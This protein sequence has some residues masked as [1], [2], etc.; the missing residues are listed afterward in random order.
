M[1]NEDKNNQDNEKRNRQEIRNQKNIANNQ[2][3][4]QNGLKGVTTAA[5]GF[6]GGKAGA[7]IGSKVG[8][9][10]NNSKVGQAA[11]N[12][13]GRAMNT[14]NNIL[15]GGR[16][17]QDTLNNTI[18]NDTSNKVDNGIDKSTSTDTPATS[19]SNKKQ[20]TKQDNETFISSSN[21][22]NKQNPL[23]NRRQSKNNKGVINK[24]PTKK[25]NIGDKHFEHVRNEKPSN[26]D[27]KFSNNQEG[28]KASNAKNTQEKQKNSVDNKKQDGKTQEK[29]GGKKPSFG[30][31]FGKRALAGAGL[32][33]GRSLFNRKSKTETEEE[34][35]TTEETTH[36]AVRTVKSIIAAIHA[37]IALLPVLGITLIIILI[38]IGIVVFLSII[39]GLIPYGQD[40]DGTVCFVAST[41][42]KVIIDDKEYDMD[43][44][45]AGA[46]VNYYKEDDLK[47]ATMTTVSD[48]ILQA[49]AVVIHSDIST[50]S[51]YDSVNE[52][53]TVNDSTRFTD[54]YDYDSSNDTS[55]TE[56]TDGGGNTEDTTNT[57]EQTNTS[58]EE[59]SSANND[60]YY[61]RAKNAAD[62]VIDKVID[63]YSQNIE[64]DYDGYQDKLTEYANVD[65][66]TI[67]RIYI[68]NSPTYEKTNKNGTD[69]E[70]TEDDIKEDSD[71]NPIGIYPICYH[72]KPTASATTSTVYGEEVCTTVHINNGEYA[73]DYTIDEYIAGVVYHEARA[74]YKTLDMMKAQAVAART[75][76]ANRATKSE[77]GTCSIDN[78]T[79]TM[80]FSP[81][82]YAEITQ[83]V[84]ETRGE[85]IMV[86]GTYASG[87]WDALC[88]TGTSGSN[89]IICQKSQQIPIS[90]FSKTT[91]FNT[92]DYYN[93]HSHG[94]GMSQYGAYYLAS[95]EGKDYKYILNYYYGG[96]VTKV[97]SASKDGYVMPITS[98]T[99]ISGEYDGYC[100]NGVP[101][102]SCSNG[103][104]KKHTGTDF[105]A[106]TGTPV[107]AAT[108]GTVTRITH[109]N[110]NCPSGCSNS[111]YDMGNSITIS[112]SDGT[113][114]RYLHLSSISVSE[115]QTVSAGDQIGL[116]GNTGHSTG[117]HLHYDM[118]DVN[119]NKVN[120]RNYI[121]LDDNGYGVCY[122]S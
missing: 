89:Y 70:I 33:L 113:K 92:I 37:L 26:T 119:G 83:A 60:A 86:D 13:A 15:P 103:V 108:S 85:Y 9:A 91:M 34:E 4:A 114:S 95:E 74:W 7:E 63:I 3:V 20:N 52:T 31:P 68:F 81:N 25:N 62:V 64:L 48:N 120:A 75:Y 96:D 53:C 49:L 109:Y 46:I 16:A 38:S 18:G 17:R 39:Q 78:S 2:K 94:R 50:Y 66:K 1:N 122:N 5:G 73:G 84:E 27:E 58:T 93:K 12:M 24:N 102:P 104:C 76:L 35:E 71:E 97:V 67:A 72:K 54:I 106:A 43:E 6:I 11:T 111:T 21:N 118:Y 110:Q 121:P 10:I 69:E 77:D 107:Y 42:T 57:Q 40:E 100:E 19:L 59:D 36:K 79:N 61:L 82:P 115:G 99:R 112:N 23:F 47:T 45:I 116:S 55:S 22:Q 90:W 56:I 105:S 8:D 14:A 51:T 41:C 80:M 29:K 44:Y 28:T 117:P 65:Y 88:T 32:G 101:T 98:F 87:E 30:K